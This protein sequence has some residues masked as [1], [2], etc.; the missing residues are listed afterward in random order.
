MAKIFNVTTDF[1]LTQ[2][3]KKEIKPG[4][5]T[6]ELDQIA[7]NEM[8]KQGIVV[9]LVHLGAPTEQWFES[10]AFYPKNGYREYKPRYMRKEL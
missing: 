9:S 10:Y 1:L 8:R 4:M 3:D 2:H 5:S 6:Y 7:E